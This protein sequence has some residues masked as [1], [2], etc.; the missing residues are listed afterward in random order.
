MM[1]ATQ[2]VNYLLS[3]NDFQYVESAL[4]DIS[5]TDAVELSQELAHQ[6]DLA[7]TAGRKAK[8]AFIRFIIE[9][10]ESKQPTDQGD[11]TSPA[12][13]SSIAES[14]IA[15]AGASAAK[16]E[17][18]EA[19]RRLRAALE[20]VRSNSPD[21]VAGSIAAI[22]IRL[23]LADLLT[24][25]GLRREA[26]DVLDPVVAAFDI[27]RAAGGAAYGLVLSCLELRALI[28]EDLRDFVSST[29]DRN[30][31]VEV[32][33]QSQRPEQLLKARGLLAFSLR[34]R[35]DV[36]GAVRE[37]STVLD[38]ALKW[39]DPD[40]IAATRN[41]LAGALLEAGR[42]SAAADEFRKALEAR[43][44]TGARGHQGIALSW[45]G[46]GSAL[47]QLG[48]ADAALAA[49]D[50]GLEAGLESN[51]R[52][53]AVAVYLGHT[54]DAG[55]ASTRQI[56]LAVQFRREARENSD[57][58]ME[59]SLCLLL[60]QLHSKRDEHNAAISVL[61]E[62]LERAKQRD[63]DVPPVFGAERLLAELLADS[64]E[65]CQEAFELLMQLYEDLVV[66]ISEIASASALSE[67]VSRHILV[68]EDLIHLLFTWRDQLRLADERTWD[69]LA[70]E[71]HEAAKSRSYLA[72]LGRTRLAVGTDVPV[73][74]LEAENALLERLIELEHELSIER[75]SRAQEALGSVRSQLEEL[76]TGLEANA[77]DYVR[78]RRGSPATL[79]QVERLLVEENSRGTRVALVSYFVG[80]KGTISFLVRPELQTLEVKRSTVTAAELQD[81]VVLLHRTFNGDATVFPPVG[82]ISRDRPHRR[83]LEFFE[84][85]SP[86]LLPEPA[87]LNGLQLL[88]I[89]PHGPLHLLPLHALPTKEKLPLS[90]GLGISYVPSASVLHHVRSRRLGVQGFHHAFIAGVAAE[91]DLRKEYFE[92][93]HTRLSTLSGFIHSV[94]GLHANKENVAAGLGRSGLAH[95]TCHGY[96]DGADPS[97]SGLILSDG[98]E[99]PPRDIGRASYLTRHRFILSTE[100]ILKQRVDAQL[101]TLR[102]CASGMQALENAGDEFV[103]LPRALLYAGAS[104]ALVALWNVDQRSSMELLTAFYRH[105]NSG[106]NNAWQ[107][108]WE[109]QRELSSSRETPAYAHLYHWAPFALI[110][111]W[112]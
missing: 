66:R 107:A 74:T 9:L 51:M 67:E 77:P 78:L 60:A 37:F 48:D 99:R 83:S 91:E 5:Y 44:H 81:V 69:V 76:W 53:G 23:Q 56:D 89:S 50:R 73:E 102:A 21:E 17:V 41:N 46:L 72:Q 105:W 104:T 62:L 57:W 98:F 71:L 30:L 4:D 15:E 88:C 40:A 95:I 18:M 96:Y 24:G 49:Y 12:D 11:A 3:L 27:M 10:V 39:G 82:P 110:G 26:L 8:A 103:G 25:V 22:P 29:A 1:D 90:A 94:S 58:L 33:E 79:S 101:V 14:A 6:V 86:E 54:V 19:V 43:T 106:Q 111:E 85:L 109:A 16:G 32:A 20:Q 75:S 47:V 55:I 93:D 45:F 108:L 92:L 63:S 97:A 65:T 70:F 80:R 59:A 42:P 7:E 36:R 100:E 2:Y 64:L 31:A 84:R 35:G 28:Y 61:R 52:L 13:P 68:I 87:S 38:H 34:K 112:R